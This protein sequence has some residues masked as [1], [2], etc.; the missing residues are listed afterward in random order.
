MNLCS[1]CKCGTFLQD[2]CST[3]KFCPRCH[4]RDL[5]KFHSPKTNLE[6]VCVENGCGRVYW[7][8]RVLP[9][10]VCMQCGGDCFAVG[11]PKGTFAAIRDLITFMRERSESAEDAMKLDGLKDKVAKALYFCREMKH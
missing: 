9:V 4:S 10:Q 8:G 5:V 1:F 3:R 6:Y 7:S 11:A 2:K